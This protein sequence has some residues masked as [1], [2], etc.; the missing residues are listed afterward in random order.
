M[1]SRV[2]VPFCYVHYLALHK[3]NSDRITKKPPQHS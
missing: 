3:K 1:A 2:E